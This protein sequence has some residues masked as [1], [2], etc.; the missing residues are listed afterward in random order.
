MTV[1][2]RSVL[3]RRKSDHTTIV[4][5]GSKTRTCR[6]ASCFY[7]CQNQVGTR[8]SARDRTVTRATAGA[9]AMSRAMLRARAMHR[10]MLRAEAGARAMRVMP[11]ARAMPK[12]RARAT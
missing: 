9:R 2:F 6:S 3:F 12:G 5:I 1:S 11:R 10:A 4:T 8:A 7:K